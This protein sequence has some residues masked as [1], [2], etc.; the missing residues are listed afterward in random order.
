M[1]VEIKFYEVIQGIHYVNHADCIFSYEHSG[2]G[3][4]NNIVQNQI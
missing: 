2:F 1:F 3:Q 4:S